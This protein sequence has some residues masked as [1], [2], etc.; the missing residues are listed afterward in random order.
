M[1]Q[2]PQRSA[3]GP[4][5]NMRQDASGPMMRRASGSQDAL[6]QSL[7]SYRDYTPSAG[8]FSGQ[9]V[10]S[11][12][13]LRRDLIGSARGEGSRASAL[14]ARSS[15]FS[16]QQGT[17]RPRQIQQMSSPQA[18]TL[19]TAPGEEM[20][21]VGM[22]SRQGS[23]ESIGSAR[24]SQV[25]S[26]Y[27]PRQNSYGSEASFR[28]FR[29]DDE[30]S[31]AST[32][33]A[34][35]TWGHYIRT[36]GN[37]I[38]RAHYASI[39]H[40][41]SSGV[42]DNEP[43]G[44]HGRD[45]AGDMQDGMDRCIGHGRRFLGG[46]KSATK[47]GLVTGPDDIGNHGHHKGDCF[48]GGIPRYVGYGRRKAGHAYKD[49]LQKETAESEPGTHGHHRGDDFKDGIQ[50]YVGNGKRRLRG[51]HDGKAPH[52]KVINAQGTWKAAGLCSRDIAIQTHSR[53][54]TRRG[55]HQDRRQRTKL[56][57][58]LE[59]HIHFDCD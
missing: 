2:T 55:T 18:A 40:F 21:Y 47:A 51:G 10:Q 6:T 11:A 38:G 33:I 26:Y 44:N 3:R 52:Q 58:N 50:F 9:M 49:H 14:S 15:R 30:V 59:D 46:H 39:D 19:R 13:D 5:S 7:R 53:D 27:L 45:K 41:K 43:P 8:G 35:A 56:Q 22:G 54:P 25:S 12:R 20:M 48:Q 57:P 28:S 16:D 37:G 1:V 4:P 24:N 31:Q 17:L 29:S 32:P 23:R 42:A 34:G 36:F